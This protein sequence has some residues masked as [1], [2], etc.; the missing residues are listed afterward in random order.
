MDGDTMIEFL[1]HLSTRAVAVTARRKP[2]AR[3]AE[4]A[5]RDGAAS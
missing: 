3:R 1:L 2:A 5:R 4:A